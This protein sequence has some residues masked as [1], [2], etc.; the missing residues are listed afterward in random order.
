VLTTKVP[1]LAGMVASLNELS[2]QVEDVKRILDRIRQEALIDKFPDPAEKKELHYQLAYLQ[3]E[4]ERLESQLCSARWKQES[5]MGRLVTKFERREYNFT[6]RE[7]QRLVR[8]IDCLYGN[9]RTLDDALRQG[10]SVP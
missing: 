1:L 10:K 5:R 3:Q 7:M 8:G 4:Y 9:T 6:P 2:G